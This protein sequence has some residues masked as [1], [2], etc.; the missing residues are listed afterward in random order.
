MRWEAKSNIFCKRFQQLTEC[1]ERAAV[2]DAWM[3]NFMMML[4]RHNADCY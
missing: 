2:S 4:P 1:F 3:F